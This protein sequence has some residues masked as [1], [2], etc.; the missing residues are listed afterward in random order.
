MKLFSKIFLL[1]F[2]LFLAAPTVI[3][4]IDENIDISLLLEL[5]EEET[6]DEIS[7]MKT[8]SS[9]VFFSCSS[10]DFEEIQKVR[11]TTLNVQKVDSMKPSTLLQPPE[12][13]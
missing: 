10:I 7:K 12:L 13:G 6:E 3:I 8:V 9:T 2:V 1:G 11:S 5:S 4:A